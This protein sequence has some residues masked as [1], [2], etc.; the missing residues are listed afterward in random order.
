MADQQRQQGKW[1]LSFIFCIFLSYVYHFEFVKG[2]RLQW[3]LQFLECSHVS[4]FTFIFLGFD[5][6]RVQL[7]M[8]VG[9]AR[10]CSSIA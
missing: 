8:G 4:A 1:L 7:T 6:A 9:F 5:L 3:R 2:S 10:V